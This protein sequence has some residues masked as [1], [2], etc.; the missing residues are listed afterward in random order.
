MSGVARVATVTCLRKTKDPASLYPGMDFF[1]LS[2]TPSI[3]EVA[4]C[5]NGSGVTWGFPAG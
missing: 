2:P 5:T 3:I 4:L 1:G